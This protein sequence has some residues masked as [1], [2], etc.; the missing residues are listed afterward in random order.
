V[1]IPI[2]AGALARHVGVVRRA[3][4][5]E[6]EGVRPQDA[7][8]RLGVRFEFQARRAYECARNFGDGDLDH[9][10][11][12]LA[13]L[14]HALKGGS[15]LSPEVELQRALVDAARPSTHVP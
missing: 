2:L 15:R 5:L 10:L 3:R 1:S 12:R 8:K 9:A 7:T 6:E 13:Q 11:L 4:R 14:D